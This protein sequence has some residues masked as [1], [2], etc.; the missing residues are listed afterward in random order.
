MADAPAIVY[1][2]AKRVSA[3]PEAS[4]LSAGAINK[5]WHRRGELLPSPLYRSGVFSFRS[6]IALPSQRP[7]KQIQPNMPRTRERGGMG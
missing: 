3:V 5:G 4:R 2:R 7:Q 6:K 1:L